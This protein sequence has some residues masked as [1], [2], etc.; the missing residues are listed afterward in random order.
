M[1]SGRRNEEL[2]L[3]PLWVSVVQ[4]AAGV[5]CLLIAYAILIFGMAYAII[6]P[7]LCIP[8]LGWAP[9][10]PCWYLNPCPASSSACPEPPQALL[11]NLNVFTLR[12]WIS[13]VHSTY[14]AQTVI[15]ILLLL[16][17]GI[18]ASSIGLNN[19]IES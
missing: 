6:L 15:C 10:G 17:M 14:L 18:T 9:W 4:F 5:V 19:T 3:R 16:A 1:Q 11:Q 12:Q 8:C 13:K 7:M 2:R